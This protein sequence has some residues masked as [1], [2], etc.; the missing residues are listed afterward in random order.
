MILK[1]IGI[2][3]KNSLF[4]IAFFEN[5]QE[6]DQK[7]Q[8]YIKTARLFTNLPGL[9]LENEKINNDKINPFSTEKIEK[10]DF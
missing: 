10:L 5:R 6:F 3:K 4:K 9:L 2:F 8:C 1:E 7:I